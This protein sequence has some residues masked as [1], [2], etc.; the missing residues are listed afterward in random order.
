MTTTKRY[1]IT[2]SDDD[3]RAAHLLMSKHRL[4]MKDLLHGAVMSLRSVPDLLDMVIDGLGVIEASRDTGSLPNGQF[5]VEVSDLYSLARRTGCPAEAILT[6]AHGL[7]TATAA[8]RAWLRTLIEC[9][10]TEAE[11]H[12]WVQ[13]PPTVE[14]ATALAALRR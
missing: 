12:T 10:P 13:A 11:A 8:D 14:E 3:A 2:L 6:L 4:G 7:P 1:T 9:G 5:P